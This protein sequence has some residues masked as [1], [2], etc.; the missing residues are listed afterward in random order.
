MSDTQAILLAVF[1]LAA[2]AFFVGAEFALISARRSQIEPRAQAGSAA[3]RITLAAMGNVSQMMAGAQLGITICSLGLGAIGE[4][5]VAHLIEPGLERASVPEDFLHPIAF[6]IALT[7]VVAL[8]VVLGEMVPK[9][10][11][12]AGPERAALVLGPALV[13]VVAVLKPF[14]VTFNAL[15]NAILSLFRVSRA[16]EVQSTYTR[17]EVLDI[18]TESHREGLIDVEEYALLSGALD[19]EERSIERI[20]IPDY[21][22]STVSR[23][24][25][26]AEI[27]ARC[28]STGFSR[29]GVVDD[30]Q[31]V[32]YV[33]IK[34][35][36]GEQSDRDLVLPD[37]AIRPLATVPADA[38]L[39]DALALMQARGTHVAA[40][41]TPTGRIAGVVMLED[42]LEQ[43]VGE[44]RDA[45]RR[46]PGL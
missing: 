33:H 4:P 28:A 25:T 6:A 34:D 5:A 19:F 24:A 27:E 41:V 3:G 35:V 1:L 42:V 12:I 29:F 2:N 31:L 46:S 16:D 32:G 44:I 21:A 26:R 36:L 14:V 39:S 17:D 23:D 8:H 22:F 37:E 18:V 40:T 7:I 30:G 43:L 38:A 20:V 45:S 13:V 9:N 15:A 10:I 11:A